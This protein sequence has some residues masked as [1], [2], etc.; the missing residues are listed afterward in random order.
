LGRIS[1]AISCLLVAVV[2]STEQV[3]EQQQYPMMYARQG[4]SANPMYAVQDPAQS[5]MYARQDAEPNPM[6][7]QGDA[8]ANPM[9]AQMMYSSRQGEAADS[10][11]ARKE[12]VEVAVKPSQKAAS[13]E[14][15]TARQLLAWQLTTTTIQIVTT[16]KTL[17]KTSLCASLLNV[18][19]ACRRRR[20]GEDKPVV[21]S[22]DDEDNIDLYKPSPVQAIETTPLARLD[23]PSYYYESLES[24]SD[25]PVRLDIIGLQNDCVLPRRFPL[26]NGLL[27]AFNITLRYTT[28]L[29]ATL[30][31]TAT[32]TSGSKP[33]FVSGCTPSPFLYSTC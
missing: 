5:S 31:V 10:M 21:L 7:A 1:F 9:Y 8:A 13:E 4:D 18:T 25:E 17:T 26:I 24:S 23:M 22:F 14:I 6:Y 33:F 2:F 3:V 27:S 20:R 15:P 28:T 30:T 29:T 32:T 11:Y 12:D 16:T 19:G